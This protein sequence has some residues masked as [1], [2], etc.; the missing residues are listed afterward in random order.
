VVRGGHRGRGDVGDE[1]TLRGWRGRAAAHPRRRGDAQRR[2][3]WPAHGH[4]GHGDR[5][6]RHGGVHG[7]AGERRVSHAL[8]DAHGAGH[9]TLV[10]ECA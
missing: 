4:R 2:Q 10:V 7:G 5:A 8:T 1:Q 9:S 6:H 3:Q